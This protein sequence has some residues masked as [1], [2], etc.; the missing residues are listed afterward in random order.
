M[1][2]GGN[3]LVAGIIF[4]A[5]YLVLALGQPPLFRIDRTGAAIIGAILMV[6]VGGLSLDDAWRSIDYRTIVLL[7]GMMVVVAHLRLS[8][9]FPVVARRV[10]AAIGHPAASPWRSSSRPGCCRR[11]S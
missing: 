5:T 6:A 2:F 11:F 7:F 8:L 10:V 4:A 1:V 9:F 3:A